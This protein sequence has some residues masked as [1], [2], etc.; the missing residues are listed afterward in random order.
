MQR[1]KDCVNSAGITDLRSVGDPFT[2]YNKNPADPIFKRLDRALVNSVWLHNFPEAQVNVLNRGIMDHNSLIIKIPLVIVPIKKSFQIF[3][4]MMEYE[5]FK[6]VVL[7]AW[8]TP[9]YVDPMAILSRKLRLVKQNLV[10]L[11]ARL[12]SVHNAV[13]LDRNELHDIQKK[14]LLDHQNRNLLIW[15]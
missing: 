10:V 3:N 8:G 5:G 1:F 4:F 11:N 9:L 7:D 12:G 6:D 13:S 14:L 15:K 2:W